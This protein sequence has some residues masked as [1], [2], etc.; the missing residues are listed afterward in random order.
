MR[1]EHAAERTVLTGAASHK[2]VNRS[3]ETNSVASVLS[4]NLSGTRPKET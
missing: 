2:S 4:A 1:M 3:Y